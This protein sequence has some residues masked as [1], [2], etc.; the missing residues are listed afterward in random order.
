MP[1]S[2]VPTETREEGPG[3]P[4]RW[5]RFTGALE[6]GADGHG[7]GE[8][9]AQEKRRWTR[10][11][12]NHYQRASAAHRAGMRADAKIHFPFPSSG[13]SAH[14]GSSITRKRAALQ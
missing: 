7:D 9:G 11:G 14:N 3:G 10:A 13:K 1:H 2:P 12:D 5:P 4:G 8:G 6:R